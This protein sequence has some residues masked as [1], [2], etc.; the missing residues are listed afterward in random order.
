[1]RQPDGTYKPPT[2]ASATLT[3]S[4]GGYTVE[5][6]DHV[7]LSFTSSG[8]LRS[9][10]DANGQ[11]WNVTSISTVTRCVSSVQTT[12]GKTITFSCTNGRETQMTL[13]DGRTVRWTYSTAGDLTSVT[14]LRGGTTTYAYDQYH[15]LTSIT[16]ANGHTTVTNVYGPQNRVIRQ[17]DALGNTTTLEWPVVGGFAAVPQ[18]RA[19]RVVADAGSDITYEVR[20]I[21]ARGHVWLDSYNEVGLLLGRTNPLGHTTQTTWDA[22]SQDLTGYTDA[23]GNSTEFDYDGNHRA[24]GFVM[25][26]APTSAT[27]NARGDVATATDGRGNTSQYAYD[28]NGNLTQITQPGG[29][30]VQLAYDGRGLL[31][32][33]TDQASKQTTLAYDAAGNLSSSTT[34]LGK[35]TTYGYDASGRVTRITDPRGNDWTI[36]YDAGD[37]V[38]SR[39]DPLGH[40]TGYGYDAVGNLT[41]VTDPNGHETQYHYDAGN[42]LTS[43]VRPGGAATSYAYDQVGNLVSRTD[44][45]GHATAYAYDAANRLSSITDPLGR[46]WTLSYDA[47]GSLTRVATPSGGAVS[48]GRDPLGRLASIGY[49]DGT[50]G[51]QFGYDGNGNRTSMSD[52]AGSVSYAYDALDRLTSVTRGGDTFAYD[53]DPVGR[54][55]SRTYPGGAETTYAWNADGLMTSASSD[56][57]TTGYSYNAA[58]I[59]SG[60]DLPNG[61]NKAMSYDAAGRLTQLENGLETIGYGYDPAGNVTSRTIGGAQQTYAYDA[62]DRLTD[63]SGGGLALH[64]GY[65][66]VGNRTSMQDDAGT[67]SYSYDAADELVSSDGSAGPVSYSHDANGDQTSNGDWSYTFDLAGQLIAADG[68]ASS[69]TYS[70]D[71][72][73]NRLSATNGWGNDELPLGSQLRGATAGARARRH[74]HGGSSLHVRAGP[75]LDGR[76]GDNRVLPRRRARHRS[77]PERAERVCARGVRGGPLRRSRFELECRPGGGRQPD[78]IHRRARR[79]NHRPGGSAG[80]ALRLVAW[81]LPLGRPA[82]PTERQRHLR[83][84]RRQPFAVLRP[85]RT[86]PREPL[87]KPVVLGEERWPLHESHSVGG[88]V[89][90][91]RSEIAACSHRRDREHLR[92]CR[93]MLGKAVQRRLHVDWGW[94]GND[95]RCRDYRWPVRHMVD[96]LLRRAVW[97]PL[98]RGGR[99]RRRRWRSCVLRWW[100]HRH[101]IWASGGRW[102]CGWQDRYA[103]QLSLRM[104]RSSGLVAWLRHEPSRTLL[105][106]AAGL[107]LVFASAVI[108]GTLIPTEPAFPPRVSWVFLPLVGTV[109]LCSVA[110]RRRKR[111]SAGNPLRFPPGHLL[112]LAALGAFA[113]T[114]SV[115]GWSLASLNGTP[116]RQND[117]YYLRNHSQLREV[118]RSKYFE[119]VATDE[120]L[121][122]A[123]ALVFFLSGLLVGR[124]REGV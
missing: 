73:G 36:G 101:Y 18:R 79:P 105:V 124:A 84:R 110:W 92:R 43:V 50:P 46:T 25:P 104:L 62:L 11:G 74:R 23:L 86:S 40:R 63:V 26:G 115:L 83:L 52:G 61:L 97:R 68:G 12:S 95:I 80:A 58:G 121:F 108:L 98:L 99:L 44:A 42:R 100:G 85:E 38:T 31:T 15:R 77:R 59:L 22:T 71:G 119:A 6:P 37:H 96:G 117:R 118:T 28:G 106:M 114:F 29:G 4:S 32:G 102:C 67:T 94:L 122:A 35:Q 123:A 27:Y 65:D 113:A 47:D 24:T 45:N 2:W 90:W 76:S 87:W 70:H 69:A 1:M 57:H 34:P 53:Y 48:Y 54:I 60:V 41:S 8:L 39:T 81:P 109:V 21:D 66:G 103:R 93:K 13:P 33:I 51:V 20:V 19:P 91:W 78:R 14:D 88:S 72:D 5:Q 55:L 49:S 30:T 120:R 111:D 16:D 64:Y 112:R 107:G 9:V 89:L 17:T 75:H 10:V 7:R 82:R 116:E 56:S 3:A